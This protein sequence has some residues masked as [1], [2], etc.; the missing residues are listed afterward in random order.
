M[1][2]T[3]L[4]ELTEF[5]RAFEETDHI[6]I[7]NFLRENGGEWILWKKRPTTIEKHGRSLG[8]PDLKCKSNIKLLTEDS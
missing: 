8:M 1:V 7:N 2:Q 5:T 6:K 4:G 3:L